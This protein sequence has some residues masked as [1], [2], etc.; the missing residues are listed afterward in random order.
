MKKKLG[1]IAVVMCMVC[2][3]GMLYG[4]PNVRGELVINKKGDVQYTPFE[5]G[6]HDIKIGERGHLIFDTTKVTTVQVPSAKLRVTEEA[7]KSVFGASI[8]VTGRIMDRTSFPMGRQ[9]F[10]ARGKVYHFEPEGLI[11]ESPAVLTLPY[12][13]IEGI[14]DSRIDIYYYDKDQAT[15]EVVPKVAQDEENKTIT[16]EINHF[17]DYM[18]GMSTFKIDEGGSIDGGKRLGESVDPYYGTLNINS[19]EVSVAARGGG[20]FAWGELQLG[21]CIYEVPATVHGER[22]DGGADTGEESEY[23]V[24]VC[25]HGY[26]FGMVV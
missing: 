1:L 9:E 7:R 3:V 8:E 16:V 25:G 14:D 15:W 23:E 24:S 12:E 11:F 2:G 6:V 26:T 17:S 13:S 20:S 4:A 5:A 22:D 21:L 18:A 10:V 19:S